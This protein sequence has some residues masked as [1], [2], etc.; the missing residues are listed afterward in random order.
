MARKSDQLQIR[1]TPREKAALK[2]AA[3]AAGQDVSQYVLARALPHARA[4]FA[5]LLALL[6]SGSDHRY[7]LAELNDLL[8]AQ[9]AGELR[10]AV[11]VAP[12][13][14]LPAFLKNYI[15]AMVEQASHSKRVSPPEWTR[16][17][18][19]LD[20]PYFAVPL[21]GLRLHLLRASPVPFKRRN[22]FID[23]ALGARV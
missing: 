20:A 21:E 23:S 8:S 5:E 10:D 13:E 9:S 2:K 1:V 17:I 12:P 3:A 22:I 7:V 14:R 19:P 4:R 11:T 15:A 16:S 18:I 6:E